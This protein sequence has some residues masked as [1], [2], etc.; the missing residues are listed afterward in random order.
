MASS[1]ISVLGLFAEPERSGVSES[2]FTADM[3][4]RQIA[5]ELDT[6]PKGLAHEVGLPLDAPKGTPLKDLGVSQTQLDDAVE[7]ILSHR[8]TTLKYSVF[9]GLVVFGLIY[10]TRI[11]R[12]ARADVSTRKQW[13]PRFPYIMA[14]LVAVTVCGFALGKSPNPM[15]GTVKVFKA[16][17]GLYP[18]VTAKLIAFTFFVAL[19]IVGNKLICGW[20]CPFGA[21]QELIF[22]L[23]LLRKVKQ[24]KLPFWLTNSIRTG[25]FVVT[26]F[27]L[28]G[29]I[30]AKKGFVV[31]HYLNPFNLF[32]LRF[33]VW[34][35]LATVV[36]ALALS[37][38]IYRPFC[39]F[40]CPFGFLSWL[41]E[42]LSLNRVR[43]NQEKCTKC[44]ICIGACPSEAAHDLV[45][46]KIFGADCFSC[47]R[48]LNVC[49]Q[50]ALRYGLV[51]SKPKSK[52]GQRAD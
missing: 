46:E 52:S 51:F 39:Y 6:S 22:S 24:R 11:G 43:I 38:A 27:I 29:V 10:L 12:P 15:E 23:P 33:E 25:L 19:A 5:P 28:F 30:G 7:H 32:D 2:H 21:L 48:C 42:P 17:V 34:T 41:A 14:L 9:V 4:L 13:Y 47:A 44:G 50:N 20:A 36:A 8:P 1:V 35:I 18:S 31:Y 37:L 26:L 16:M 49:P 45:E 3:S 40:I